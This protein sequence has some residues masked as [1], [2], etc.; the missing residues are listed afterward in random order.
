ME[1]TEAEIGRIFILRLEDGDRLP[2][3][4]EN[5]AVN[6]DIESATVL[7]IGGAD[8][9]SQVIA[10]PDDGEAAEP[11]PMVGSLPGV[12]EAVGVGTIFTN[13]EDEPKLHLHSAFGRE[14]KTITGCTRAGVDIWHIGEVVI[15]ELKNH[16]ACRKIDAETGFELLEV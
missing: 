8:K 9:G 3:A 14:A 10:G 16:S 15:W 11:L 12:S 1:Y 4:I 7:F 2:E 6:K 13:E 5:F